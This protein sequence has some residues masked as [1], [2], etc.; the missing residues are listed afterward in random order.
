MLFGVVNF[1]EACGDSS[2]HCEK[3]LG[4]GAWRVVGEEQIIIP[5]EAHT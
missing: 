5:V 4:F 3:Q 1:P 2:S